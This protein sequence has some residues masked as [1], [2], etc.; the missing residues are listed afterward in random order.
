M[1]RPS[2]GPV[3]G[4]TKEIFTFLF[5]VLGTLDAIMLP[6]LPKSGR[7]FACQLELQRPHPRQRALNHD[8]ANRR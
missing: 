6:D 3:R 2:L 1:A 7:Q 4:R 5:G 8:L